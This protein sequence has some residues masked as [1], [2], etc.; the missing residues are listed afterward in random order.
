MCFGY[1]YPLDLKK[2]NEHELKNIICVNLNVSPFVLVSD[3]LTNLH[4]L[5]YKMGR[6]RFND[7]INSESKK[8]GD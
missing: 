1:M 4:N 8:L 3:K 6:N 7:K 2:T 5:H